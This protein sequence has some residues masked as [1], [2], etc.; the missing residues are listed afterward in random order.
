[1]IHITKIFVAEMQDKKLPEDSV[2]DLARDLIKALQYVHHLDSVHLAHALFLSYVQEWS[3]LSG[4]CIPRELYIVIW[5]PRTFYWMKMDVQRCLCIS[6]F[7]YAQA[8]ASG[9][10]L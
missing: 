10:D 3:I 9:Y 7:L 5:S 8:I 1:M 2:H 6:F 4:I